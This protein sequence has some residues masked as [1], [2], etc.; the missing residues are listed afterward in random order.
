MWFVYKSIFA[1]R[2]YMSYSTRKRT[3]DDIIVK[4]FWRNNERFAD[5]FNAVLFKGKCVI[6]AENLQAAAR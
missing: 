6:K 1:E 5:L 3:S 4:E 2:R